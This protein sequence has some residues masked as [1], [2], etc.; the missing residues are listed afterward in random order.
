MARIFFINVLAIETIR[1]QLENM[2]KYLTAKAD[3]SSEKRIKRR[4]ESSDSQ[5]FQLQYLDPLLWAAK[6]SGSSHFANVP[7]AD[8][9]KLSE[10]SPIFFDDEMHEEESGFSSVIRVEPGREV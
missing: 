3:E 7:D 8:L 6:L 9:S 1:P 2:H 5:L 10:G 4:E